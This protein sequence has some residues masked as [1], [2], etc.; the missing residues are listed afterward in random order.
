VFIIFAHPKFRSD[1]K[2]LLALQECV[3]SYKAKKEALLH[4]DLHTGNLLATSTS[5][6][7]IDWVCRFCLWGCFEEK[8]FLY[9]E[10]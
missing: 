7:C 10:F 8:S 9:P 6:Y 5:T 4:N 1:A 3:H 2:V